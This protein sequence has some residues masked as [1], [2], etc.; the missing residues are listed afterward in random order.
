[1]KMNSV[2]EAILSR[3]L[4][5]FVTQ[6]AQAVN[7]TDEVEIIETHNVI[8]C[9]SSVHDVHWDVFSSTDVEVV[10]SIV[11]LVLRTLVS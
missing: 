7:Q 2:L 4:N 10:T 5:S 3:R 9:R 11:S 1:M 8:H 6:S